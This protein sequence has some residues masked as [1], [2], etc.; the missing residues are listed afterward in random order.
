LRH[1]GISD[2]VKIRPREYVHDDAG[3]SSA[4]TDRYIGVELTARARSLFI[5]GTPNSTLLGFFSKTS[6]SH[7]ICDGTSFSEVNDSFI[8]FS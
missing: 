8:N 5:D 6:H 4:I 2:G 1:T 3:H 7:P